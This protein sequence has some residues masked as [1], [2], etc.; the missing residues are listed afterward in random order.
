MKTILFVCTG[1]TCRSTMAEGIFKKMI[2]DDEHLKH[3]K[4]ISAGTSVYFPIGAN[5]NAIEAVADMGIDISRHISTPVNSKMIQEA[6]LVLTMT[7]AHKQMVINM[8]PEAQ[9][10][11]FTIKEFAESDIDDIDI[12]DPY[13][14]SIDDYKTCAKDIETQLIKVKDKIIMIKK[15]KK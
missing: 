12:P 14:L 1:N 5:Q 9:E 2:I 4:I 7:E 3:T 8:V 10:K 6:D 15:V 13:G 11:T